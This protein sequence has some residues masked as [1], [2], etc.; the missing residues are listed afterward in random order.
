MVQRYD[1]IIVGAGPAGSTA[2][3]YAARGGASVLFI[4][5]R[6]EIGVPVQCGEFLPANN[7]LKEMLPNAPGI[8]EVFDVDEKLVQ[9]RTEKIVLISPKGKEYAIGFEGYTVNRDELDRRLADT[10]VKEGAKLMADTKFISIKG[11]TILTSR[12]K[13]EY[14]VLVAADGPFSGVC[15]SASLG[16]VRLHSPAITC[17]VKGDF[18]DV[19]KMYFGKRAAPGGYAWVIPKSGCANVGLGIQKSGKPLIRHL[20]NFLDKNNFRTKKVSAG[21][22]PISGPI[23]RTVNGDILAVGDAAGQ[24]MATNGGGVPIAMICGRL[25]GIAAAKRVKN[26]KPLDN[27]E[28]EWRA[29]VGKE[30]ATAVKTKRLADHFFRFDSTLEFAM[31]R[32]GEKGLERAI[33]CRRVFRG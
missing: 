14:R 33:R 32:L 25:A 18:D 22:V 3:K 4:D 29:A 16:L 31:K 30:L 6:K 21:F 11:H 24:V 10:A 12:G 26:N 5:K 19:V 8:D 17:Q 13:F 7:E 9:R 28:K 20:R 1:V 27:Y 15:R 23:K 2:A